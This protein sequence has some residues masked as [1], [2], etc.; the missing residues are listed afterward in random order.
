MSYT[1]HSSPKKQTS[2]I[3]QLCIIDFDIIFMLLY[4][5]EILQR[6]CLVRSPSSRV[7]AL[8]HQL[9]TIKVIAILVCNDGE[10]R[11]DHVRK[12]LSFQPDIHN[13]NNTYHVALL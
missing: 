13:N 9:G 10:A 12:F 4:S 1:F 11:N 5:Q 8:A 6:D 2:A 3:I 7:S